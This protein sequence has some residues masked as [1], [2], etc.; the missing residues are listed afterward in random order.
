MAERA[1]TPRG[2]NHVVLNVRGREIEPIIL[3]LAAGQW[4]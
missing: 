4:R 2:V 1:Q 3:Q